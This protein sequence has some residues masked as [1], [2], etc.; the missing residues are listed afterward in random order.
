MPAPKP[1]KLKTEKK[2]LLTDSHKRIAD[3]EVIMQDYISK[4]PL[5][6]KKNQFQV[7]EDYFKMVK[8]THMS[9]KRKLE[10]DLLKDNKE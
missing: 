3:E 6:I 2:E 9:A 10:L 4:V 8:R 5:N 7:S 1:S